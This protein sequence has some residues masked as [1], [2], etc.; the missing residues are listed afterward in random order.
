M[1]ASA[2][3][4]G[5]EAVSMNAIDWQTVRAALAA[6]FA[7]CEVEFRAMLTPREYQGG[8][9]APVAA[10]VDARAIQDRLDDVVGP[11]FWS[12]IPQVAATANGAV[13]A[14]I[15]LLSVHGVVKGDIG[16]AEAT[17]RNKASVSDALK[18]AAVQWGIGR[19]LYKLPKMYARFVKK[20]KD[21]KL[22]DGELERLRG[23]LP[24][25]VVS[26]PYK[27]KP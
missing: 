22:A 4:T 2:S 12:F 10:Y 19:Y 6:P 21:W 17:E 1:V 7:P 18:R 5:H 11:Q 8:Y 9:T 25:S 3:L 26:N 14:A 23:L 16:D 27:G 24:I 20:G 13:T 15:G